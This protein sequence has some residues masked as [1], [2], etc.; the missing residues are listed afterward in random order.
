MGS[1][2]VI[3]MRTLEYTMTDQW[4]MNNTLRSMGPAKA[5]KPINPVGHLMALHMQDKK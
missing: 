4:G 1:K 5:I 3:A 2:I